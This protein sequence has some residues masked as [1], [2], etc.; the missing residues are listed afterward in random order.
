LRVPLSHA[1]PYLLL[2]GIEPVFDEVRFLK[3]MEVFANDRMIASLPA[4]AM[5]ATTAKK[6]VLPGSA[7]HEGRNILRLRAVYSAS[8]DSFGDP[9]LLSYIKVQTS[10][11]YASG[12]EKYEKRDW[13]GAISDLQRVLNSGKRRGA[14]YYFLGMSY[15]KKENYREAV[16]NFTDGLSVSRGNSTILLARGESYFK[17][18][19]PQS[20]IRDLQKVLKQKPD[21]L[22]AHYYMALSLQRLGHT[23]EAKAHLRTLAQLAPSHS[24]VLELQRLLSH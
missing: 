1:Q 12:L 6:V 18:G 19:D 13:D 11:L 3:H 16:A 8:Q 7:L 4:E 5:M 24:Y 15:L 23:N 21:S 20:A 22:E 10:D 17:M 2:L 9:L 14:I